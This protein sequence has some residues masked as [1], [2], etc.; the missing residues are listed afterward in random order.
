LLLL[1]TVI[2]IVYVLYTI[3]EEGGLK[4]NPNF[5]MTSFFVFLGICRYLQLIYV[6]KQYGNPVK[7]FYTD[8][9]ML[10]TWL[11]WLT[12]IVYFIYF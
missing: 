3:S 11:G 4:Y 12:S 7:I 6:Q 1:A 5:Y 9:T 8:T 10:F 2:L